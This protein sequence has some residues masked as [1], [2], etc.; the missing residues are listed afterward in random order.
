MQFAV[1]EVWA[2]QMPL[3]KGKS[4]QAFSQ[5]VKTEMDAGK[6]Q[7]QSLA[8]AYAMKRKAKKMAKGGGVE[9][10]HEE[11][12]RMLNQHGDDETGP[13]HG[14]EGFHGESYEGNPGDATDNHYQ[15]PEHE[16]DMVTRIMTKMAKSYS[17]GGRVANDTKDIA[18]FAPNNFDDLALRD[19]LESSY[20][21]ANSG[22]EQ[23]DAREDHDR[24]DIVSRVMASRKKKDRLPNPR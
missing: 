21:G 3:N 14:G 9:A 11:D 2:K 10:A 22:D 17:K 1:Q 6:P 13:E 8:I 19:N 15:T 4:K 5:N 24:A 18:D 16:E 20:T 7:K 12:S 23:G